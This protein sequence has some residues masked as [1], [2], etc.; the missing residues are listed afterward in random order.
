[1]LAT[2][3]KGYKKQLFD[4]SAHPLPLKYSGDRRLQPAKIKDLETM[5][6]YMDTAV[7]KEWWQPLVQRQKQLPAQQQGD[8]QEGDAESDDNTQDYYYSPDDWGGA[9]PG[10]ASQ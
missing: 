5:V 1:M 4:L 10:T 8:D 3:Q 7:N 2:W 6:N 9:T